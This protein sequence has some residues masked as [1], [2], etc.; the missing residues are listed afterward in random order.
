MKVDIPAFEQASVLVVGDIMLDRYWYGPTQRISPEAPVPIVKINQDE[1]RP[2]GA[3][4]V[5]LNIASIGGKVTLVGITGEDE[6]A[7]H[8]KTQILALNIACEFDQQENIPTITKLRVMSR[9]QQ[10]IRL[11]F[12]ESFSDVDKKLLEDKVAVQLANHDLL[13]L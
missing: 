12:E 7:Q 13:L 5:A 3:A 11:D 2:G 4:N 10:L 8:L 6:A 9:N 1:H